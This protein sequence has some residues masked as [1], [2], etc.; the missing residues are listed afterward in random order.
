MACF[1]ACFGGGSRPV[2]DGWAPKESIEEERTREQ[3]REAFEAAVA[4]FDARHPSRSQ[5]KSDYD[6]SIRLNGGRLIVAGEIR[7][8]RP[9]V[10]EVPT[11]LLLT[12]IFARANTKNNNKRI[13][14]KSVLKREVARFEKEHIQQGTA[15]GE[16]DH[17]NYASRYFRNLNLPNV[18]HQVL[19]VHWQGDCLMGTIEILPTPSGLLL[20]ELYSQGIRLGVSSR[21]W[22]SLR[23]DPKTELIF[24]DDDFELITFDFVTEPSTRDAFLFP[25]LST[26]PA[27]M[28]P[29][30]TKRTQISHLGH[31]TCGMGMIRNLPDPVAFATRINQ[32]Q[33]QTLNLM[34][35]NG[36]IAPQLSNLDKLLV[37]S[38]YIVLTDQ[39][40]LDREA[41]FRDLNS[42]LAMFATRAHLSGIQ[43]AMKKAE[44]NAYIS[45][46]MS[47]SSTDVTSSSSGDAYSI[48]SRMPHHHQDG[49]SA[50]AGVSSSE[51]RDTRCESE[52][53]Q[54]TSRTASGVGRVPSVQ[55]TKPSSTSRNNTRPW[56]KSN[57]V[58]PEPSGSSKK[59][60]E[61]V[62]REFN[63][64][65]ATLSRYSSCLVREQGLVFGAVS[66][67]TP[68]RPP[69]FPFL[70]QSSRL[71]SQG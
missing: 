6:E 19:E 3:V 40:Y 61:S 9:H 48:S 27:D 53:D 10:C 57:R 1:L 21:G 31:G 67:A 15:L 60:P 46:E 65:R 44:M 50:P 49:F 71:I 42:H 54:W 64:I 17:P 33:G 26:Y 59:P 25:L 22:A 63:L 51:A 11:T 43:P 45:S 66:L 38:H 62:S 37:Y 56:T 34:P 30:Q 4:R 12:G 47:R 18:S 69:Q 36:L 24:V 39:P 7:Q 20:R 55:S 52:N 23:T 28:I 29:N 58:H 41:N 70:S 5:M 8:M 14:P 68:F 2:D 35:S 16:V 13:Y 32:L